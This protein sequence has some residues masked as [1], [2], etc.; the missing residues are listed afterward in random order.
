[1]SVD[2]IIAR[3]AELPI[4][5]QW[6]VV[7]EVTRTL[8]DTIDSPGDEI[9]REE[10]LAKWRPELERRWAAYR[11][12]EVEP[13]DAKQVIADTRAMLERNRRS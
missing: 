13:L 10:W 12:G 2:E 3:V 5:E 6:R 11:A 8:D 9:G 1:M 7:D 4:E